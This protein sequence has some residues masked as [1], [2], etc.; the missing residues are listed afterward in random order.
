MGKDRVPNSRPHLGRGSTTEKNAG[1]SW[2]IWKYER[3]KTRWYMMYGS[4]LFYIYIYV[5]QS[6]N[7]LLHIYI[8]IAICT[9]FCVFL[10]G[11]IYIYIYGVASKFGYG[12]ARG[13]PDVWNGLDHLRFGMDRGYGSSCGFRVWIGAL[14]FDSQPY[15][16]NKWGNKPNRA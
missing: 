3:D 12:S 1:I 8:Y 15:I 4:L 9:Q 5:W 13:D 7:I 2:A 14:Y 10:M 6:G 16:R 11:N